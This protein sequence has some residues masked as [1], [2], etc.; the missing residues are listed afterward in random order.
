MKVLITGIGGF[1][2]SHLADQDISFCGSYI[3][4]IFFLTRILK[5]K[6]RM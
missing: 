2:G 3:W 1:A 5:K 6:R 4:L